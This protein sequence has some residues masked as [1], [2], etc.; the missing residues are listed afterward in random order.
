MTIIE[1]IKSGRRLRR[2]DKPSFITI[3]SPDA[4]GYYTI[5]LEINDL[6]ADDWEIEEEKVTVTR[7]QV[8]LAMGLRHASMDVVLHAL[9]FR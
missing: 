7:E 2:K 6:L 1:A 8:A 5:T 3:D 9:G 4:P